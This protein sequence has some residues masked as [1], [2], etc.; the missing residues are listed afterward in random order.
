M[1]PNDLSP[2][3]CGVTALGERCDATLPDNPQ[4]TLNYHFGMLL[5][6]DDFQAEQGFH[7]GRSRRH[8]RL[9][10]GSGVV[11]GYPVS[12]DAALTELRVGPG[13]AVDAL[14]RDL[15]LDQTQCVN[16]VKWWL[17]HQKEE[18]FADLPSLTDATFDLD[19]VV[20]YSTCLSSPVPAVAEPCA[21][22]ASDIAYSRVCETVTLQLVRAVPVEAESAPAPAPGSPPVSAAEGNSDPAPV[23]Q[24]P[25]DLPWPMGRAALAEALAA[26][27]I[28]PP[29]PIDSADLCL[30]L[31]RLRGLH[32][33]QAADGWTAT[34]DRIDLTVRPLL[35]ATSVL[36]NLLSPT[37]AT[38]AYGAGPTVVDDEPSL[39]PDDLVTLRFDQALAPASVQPEA[40]AVSEFDATTGWSLIAVS[41]ATYT[42]PTGPFTPATVA[43][44]LEHPVT[45]AL[46]RVA[47]IGTGSTPLLGDHLIP[48]GAPHPRADGRVIVITLHRG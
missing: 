29:D 37:L 31:A 17:Q 9:L 2:D 30:P 39:S 47:V 16:L 46:L 7:L 33:Q 20:C 45:G 41:T 23:P 5:G 43:L 21:G 36:Q 6:V 8:Q 32:L 26:Q 10:H 12:F 13:L 25:I 1:K 28:A 15:A 35:L 42:A 18:A 14:G 44:Q 38:P 19:I 22:Q 11:A 48:A 27:S 3:G 24:P 4:C 40:F 34:V